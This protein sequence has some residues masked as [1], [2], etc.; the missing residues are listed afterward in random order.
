[1]IVVSPSATARNTA[2]RSAHTVNPSDAFSTLHPRVM[3]P[4]PVSTAAPTGK[5]LY[6]Q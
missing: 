2:L 1:M 3:E 6:G 5:P 4:L